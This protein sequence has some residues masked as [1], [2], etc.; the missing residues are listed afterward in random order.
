MAKN[1]TQLSWKDALKRNG[2]AWK[3]IGRNQPGLFGATALSAIFDGLG[4]YVTIY[5]SA[6]I[7]EELAGERPRAAYLS[8][9]H[10]SDCFCRGSVWE[11]H[12]KKVGTDGAELL[13]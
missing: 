7:I 4:P 8:C 10:L 3:T 2:R 13:L 6:R 11:R 1:E 12:L 9:H 5:L